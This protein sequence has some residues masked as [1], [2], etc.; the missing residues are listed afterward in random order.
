L[1]WLTR[2]DDATARARRALT[3]RTMLLH[4]FMTGRSRRRSTGRRRQAARRAFTRTLPLHR[5]ARD[6]LS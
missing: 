4:P 3:A 1:R 6:S 5:S 2:P